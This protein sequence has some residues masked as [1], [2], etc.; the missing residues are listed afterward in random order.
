MKHLNVYNWHLS[1]PSM[2]ELA[3]YPEFE[4]KS[5]GVD[6]AVVGITMTA[7]F[8]NLDYQAVEE[9][10]RDEVSSYDTF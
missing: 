9:V 3:L 4:A 1:S 6:E 2:C 7:D 10:I 5:R 8:E